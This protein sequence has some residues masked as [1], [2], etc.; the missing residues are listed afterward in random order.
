[1]EA[2]REAWLG[3]AAG[4]LPVDITKT[5]QDTQAERGRAP[6]VG[7]GGLA[8]WMPRAC[9]CRRATWPATT[10]CCATPS[11]R[12]V[13]ADLRGCRHRLLPALFGELAR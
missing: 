4:Q 2:S 13:H 12:A 3:V 9:H 10:S 8:T 1:V 11:W 7:P 5:Y 6:A